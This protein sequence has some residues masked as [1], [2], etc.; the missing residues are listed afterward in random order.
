MKNINKEIAIEILEKV[1]EGN[2]K[3]A[4]IEALERNA[5]LTSSFCL[6][7]CDMTIYK[8]GFLLYLY[9]T[10]C[11]FRVFAFDNDGELEVAERKPQENKLNKI[12]STFLKFDESDF[13]KITKL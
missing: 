13:Y 6:E 5:F 2:K 1:V 9:G 8:E 11:S 3:E 7:N 12:Y 4:L 10:R